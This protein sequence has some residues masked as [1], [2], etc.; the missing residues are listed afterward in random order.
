MLLLAY[1]LHK[2]LVAL[3]YLLSLWCVCV[4][5]CWILLPQLQPS[6]W[7]PVGQSAVVNLLFV[8]ALAAVYCDL[9]LLLATHFYGRANWR[10]NF[11][12]C[13]MCAK[14]CSLHAACHTYTCRCMYIRTLSFSLSPSLSVVFS[15]L[16][17]A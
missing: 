14:R 11:A 2:R 10:E 5:L 8:V 17:S 1:F 3:C 16:P 9:L 13:K 4:C 15:I 12:S 6:P 7:Q